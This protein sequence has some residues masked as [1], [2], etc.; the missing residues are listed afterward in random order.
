MTRV[1]TING[2]FL[3]QPIT[4]VQRYARELTTALDD[5]LAAGHPLSDKLRLHLLTP[6][7]TKI[8]MPPLKKIEVR[9]SR[10]TTTGHLWEQIELP[11]CREGGILSLCNTT[12]VLPIRQI[13][14]IHD[15][16]TRLAP[17]SYSRPF[18][19]LYRWLIPACAR[20]SRAV[21]TVSRFS[22]VELVQ[23]RVVSPDRLKVIPNGHEH[24]LRWS[25]GTSAPDPDG[26]LRDTILV[27]GSTAPHKNIGMLLSLAPA[28]QAHG[29]SLA[30][31]G[32]ADARVFSAAEPLGTQSNVRFL[33]RITDRQ[34]ADL[35]QGCLCLAF[36]S[37]TE[38]FG[39]PPLEAMALGC[40]VVVSNRASLP[41]VCGNAALYAS[42]DEPSEW[43]TAFRRLKEQPLARADS[44]REGRAR[45][46]AFSWAQ[47][48]ESYLE[49]MATVD[50]LAEHMQRMRGKSP[51]CT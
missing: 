45:A 18:R 39:L 23:H 47:S 17:E 1:W 2:R 14:C 32:Q 20:A 16:N 37:F 41:E 26:D 44:I 43:V 6:R 19:T 12:S 3:T 24:A 50:G 31:I 9:E 10:G 40:P 25:N 33:G 34:L 22:A 42:P 21:T 35:L 29:L 48:A 28:L 46:K 7:G 38:G 27:I 13:V 15:L 8:D 5:L 4:G 36:P 30:I 11:L 49:L 51:C